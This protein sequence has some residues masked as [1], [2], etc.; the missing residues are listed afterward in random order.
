M[1]RILEMLKEESIQD[2]ISAGQI[3]KFC[4]CQAE[5]RLNIPLPVMDLGV[6]WEGAEIN[7][8]SVQQNTVTKHCRIL[9]PDGIRRA[10]G[11]E[12]QILQWFVHKI[13]EQKRIRHVDKRYGI[14]FS[15]G[16]GKG[17]YQTG[18]WKYLNETGLDRL[19]TGISGASVGALNSLLFAQEDY[20]LAEQIWLDI[21]QED[22]MKLSDS[23]PQLVCA[24]FS[25]DPLTL[26]ANALKPH[27]VFTQST[28]RDKVNQ[29]YLAREK[30]LSG[31]KLIYSSLSAAA[32]PHLP[33]KEGAVMARFFSALSR[34]EYFCWAG[35][36]WDTLM[37]VVL[38]S[39]ALPLCYKPLDLADQT[40]LDGGVQDN[41]PVKPLIE[42]G[43]QNII[44][45]HL[46]K[47]KWEAEWKNSTAGI[48]CRNVKFFH[49]HPGEDFDDSLAAML[50]VNPQITRT[51]IEQGYRDAK[52]QLCALGSGIRPAC[53]G[54]IGR[55]SQ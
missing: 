53:G 45:I 19:I 42:A 23:L 54:V 14:V 37:K 55:R 21:R 48:D 22:M 2:I 17:A 5:R 28:I 10:Y 20:A 49:V 16:G 24:L 41:V 47:S 27:A 34:A 7:G 4:G 15:G 30:I 44:V 52:R 43:F 51:R 3:E 18:V 31:Q 6:F 25:G 46:L 50:T 35:L 36:D 32:L 13:D 26:A 40:Y 8:W 39:A 1:N 12:D 33:R 29:L 38:A 11:T 9:D